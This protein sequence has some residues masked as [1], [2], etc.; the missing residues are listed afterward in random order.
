MENCQISCNNIERAA[1]WQQGMMGFAD[2]YMN[3]TQDFLCTTDTVW[4]EHWYAY[5]KEIDI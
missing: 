4:L 1:T 2:I 5:I 3:T